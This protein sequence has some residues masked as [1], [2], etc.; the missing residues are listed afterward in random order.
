[1]FKKLQKKLDPVISNLSRPKKI[2]HYVVIGHPM[3]NE[4]INNPSYTIKIGTDTE[5][6]CEVSIDGGDWS[7]CRHANSFWWFDWAN[8]PL[9]D[10]SIIAR[11]CDSKGSVVI[12]KSKSIKCIYKR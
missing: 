6:Y 1:M 3:E 4:I 10:H 12:C 9:G 7:R 11:I 8:Y 2:S 5:G